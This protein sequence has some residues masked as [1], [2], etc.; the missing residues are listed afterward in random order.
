M[1]DLGKRK[2]LLAIANDE[3]IVIR[4]FNNSVKGTV[5]KEP[6]GNLLLALDRCNLGVGNFDF[7]SEGGLD[8]QVTIHHADDFSLNY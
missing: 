5:V 2:R 7:S 8:C 3:R 4:L 1:F 6:E